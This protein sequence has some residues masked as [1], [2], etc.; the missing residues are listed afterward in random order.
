VGH[1]QVEILFIVVLLKMCG[2][3]FEGV[4]DWVRGKR[5]E[6][7]LVVSIVGTMT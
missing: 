2:V 6:R 5:G 4:G 1:L 3:F 7:D